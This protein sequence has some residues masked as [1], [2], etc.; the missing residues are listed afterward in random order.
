MAGNKKLNYKDIENNKWMAI[1]AYILP[2]VAYYSKAKKKSKWLSFHARQGMNLFLVELLF[3]L[4]SIILL[5]KIT[6][7]RDCTN[8][9]YGITYYCGEETPMYLKICVLLVGVLLVVIAING[10]VNVLCKE[11]VELPIIGKLNLFK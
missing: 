2:P 5:D 10:I 3:S 9:L 7:L 8:Y 6:V 1:M 11:K 4:I